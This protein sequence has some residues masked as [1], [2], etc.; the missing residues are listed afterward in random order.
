MLQPQQHIHSLLSKNFRQQYPSQA[1]IM[2]NKMTT[3]IPAKMYK[4]SSFQVLWI[5]MDFLTYEWRNSYIMPKLISVDYSIRSQNF[6]YQITFVSR[7][8]KLRLW[9][10]VRRIRKQ[11]RRKAK[12]SFSTFYPIFSQAA[13]KQWKMESRLASTWVQVYCYLWLLYH[14]FSGLLNQKSILPT[15]CLKV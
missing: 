7:R 2:V 6:S 12:R 9:K 11:K 8:H 15:Q 14:R 3:V 5:F 4:K 10:E 1:Q 13:F